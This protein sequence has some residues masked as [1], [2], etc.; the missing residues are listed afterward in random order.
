MQF[1]QFGARNFARHFDW[2]GGLPIDNLTYAHIDWNKTE[3]TAA[4]FA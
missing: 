2:N 1:I 3:L 4:E